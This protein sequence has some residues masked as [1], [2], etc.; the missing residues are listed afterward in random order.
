MVMIVVSLLIE[1]KYKLKVDN[2]NV[3]FPIQFFLG[4][5]YNKFGAINSREVSS[6]ENVYN[7]PVDCNA[8]NKSDILNI[9]KYLMIKNNKKY[10][11]FLK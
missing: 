8:I 2:K 5:I 3:D 6:E 10:L 7:F 4:S 9:H 1:K 11:D